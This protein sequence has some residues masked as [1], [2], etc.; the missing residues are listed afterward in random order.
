MQMMCIILLQ[1]SLGFT[2]RMRLWLAFM[3]CAPLTTVASDL[4]NER[5]TASVAAR[6]AH[7]GVDCGAM[8]S[9]LQDGTASRAEIE[10]A[11]TKCRFIHQ[12]PGVADVENCPDYRALLAAY[13]S[14]DSETLQQALHGARHCQNPQPAGDHQHD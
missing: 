12:P 3:L 2:V 6:E 13:R 7:W 1:Q 5:L 4:V 9:T 8:L 14:N 11:L 10:E